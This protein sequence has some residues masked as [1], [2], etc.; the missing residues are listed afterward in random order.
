VSDSQPRYRGRVVN[1]YCDDVLLPNGH[2][3][4]LEVVR[5]PGGASVVAIDAEGQVCLIRQYRHAVGEW[6]WE[7]PAGRLEPQEPPDITAARELEE[8]AGYRAHRWQSLGRI[9]SSPGVFDEIIHLYLAQELTAVGLRQEP[10]ELIEVHWFTF[11]SAMQMVQSGQI[12]DAKTIVGLH[13]AQ[14]LLT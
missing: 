11:A 5:H 10:G 6:I 8:E 13:R 14:A 1:V 9:L 7:L 3:E 4:T 2:R 12:I